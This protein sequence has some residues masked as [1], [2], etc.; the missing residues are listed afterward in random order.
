MLKAQDD[1]FVLEVK[2]KTKI[3]KKIVGYS[4]IA[5]IA[6][7]I[8]YLVFWVAVMTD[9][10][11]I[12]NGGKL[13]YPIAHIFYPN[14]MSFKV[15]QKTGIMFFKLII[16]LFLVH[17]LMDK[18][19]D[20]AVEQYG[21][22]I[23]K[24]RREELRKQKEEEEAQQNPQDISEYSI[25][26]SIDYEGNISGE[27]EEKLDNIIFTK[28][29]EI[30]ANELSDVHM[31]IRKK[32]LI[33]RSSDFTKFDF[34]FNSL[35]KILSKIKNT[36]DSKYD[37]EFTPSI[38]IDAMQPS[39]RNETIEK[40]HFEIQTFNFKNR[41]LS[42]IIFAKKYKFMQNEKYIGIPIGEYAYFDKKSEKKYE[43]NVIF[44]NLKEVLKTLK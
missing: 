4:I 33:I 9:N 18:I 42:T 39:K 25:C 40:E 36:F 20:K 34:L 17:Y 2:D 37:F 38:T 14:D 24:R 8:V 19:E 1:S 28:T 6:F 10:A 7:G 41:A 27:V 23:E 29:K 16:P 35:L 44:K 15:F 31:F 22:I 32:T 11:F 13:F 12:N 30:F 43:L 5:C 3:V 26:F 21:K